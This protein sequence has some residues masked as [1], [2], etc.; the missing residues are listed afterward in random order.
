MS[1]P[2]V[3]SQVKQFCSKQAK[4]AVTDPAFDF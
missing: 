2:E 3:A 4:T 1:K